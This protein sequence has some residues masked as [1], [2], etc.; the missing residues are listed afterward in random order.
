MII[1]IYFY[2]YYLFFLSFFPFLQRILTNL[3]SKE[4]KS[5]FRDLYPDQR[6]FIC[7]NF[8]QA[9]A[10]SPLIESPDGH[11]QLLEIRD[12]T[13]NWNKIRKTIFESFV[14]T[15]FHAILF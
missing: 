13:E 7:A 6:T 2:N 8:H 14:S 11:T 10:G 3:G 15:S 1:I 5:R 4:S 12:A 9:L